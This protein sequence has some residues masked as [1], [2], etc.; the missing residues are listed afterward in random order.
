MTTGE[1]LVVRVAMKPISTLMS[2][3]QTVDLTT[4]GGQRPERALGRDRG[5]RDGCHRG[6][7]GGAGA[8][9][10][11]A[12]EIRRRLARRNAPQRDRAT[13]RRS[14]RGGVKWDGHEAGARRAD[15]TPRR[16]QEHRRPVRRG[17]A[18]RGLRGSRRAD[19][20]R[21][22]GLFPRSSRSWG[23]AHFA[24]S[25]ATD[26]EGIDRAAPGDRHVAA[27]GLPSLAISRL[28]RAGASWCIWRRLPRPRRCASGM[29]P[30]GLFLPVARCWKAQGAAR[31]A[32]E[33]LSPG[34]S[35]DHDRRDDGYAGRPAIAALAR[36]HGGL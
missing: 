9:G 36:R 12:G 34:G 24:R 25:S 28:S 16:G 30:T 20:V 2:P 29:R 13:S 26:G 22:G 14:G 23:R 11:D 21:G 8:G 27:A 31:P 6:G 19:R 35:Y 15:G 1:P 4:G 33:V 10:R 32:R 17:A 3:L 18:R 5:A 7:D